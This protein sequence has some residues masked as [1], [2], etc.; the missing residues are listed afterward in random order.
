MAIQF[1]ILC[2][3]YQDCKEVDNI[4]NTL[5]FKTFSKSLDKEGRYIE[6]LSH[7]DAQT[8]RQIYKELGYQTQR[9]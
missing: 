1:R 9:V 3:S 6:C 4:A 8:L 2:K 7:N 5:G